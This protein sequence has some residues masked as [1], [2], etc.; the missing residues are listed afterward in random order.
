MTLRAVAWDVDGTLVDS[1]PLHH[2]AL[3]AACGN[4]GADVSDLSD[5]A[6]RG[7]HLHDVWPH[8]AP[9]LPRGI[10]RDDWIAAIN[11]YYTGH[12]HRLAPVPNA[13]DAVAAIA[14]AGFVQVCVSNSNRSIVD[15]NIAALGIGEWIEFSVSLDDVVNG[16]PHPEPYLTA[17]AR[18]GLAPAQVIAVEDSAAGR[19]SACAAGLPVIVYESVGGFAQGADHCIGNL[20]QVLDV[21]R[22]Y[23]PA[24]HAIRPLMTD[25]A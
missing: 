20:L 10:E 3:V 1:E 11:C 6:F 14:E 9:R 15:A 18:L 22:S 17:C 7:V 21:L 13:A 16:K 24:R 4:W 19:T 5:E 12:C 2:E 8:I 25:G 23:R